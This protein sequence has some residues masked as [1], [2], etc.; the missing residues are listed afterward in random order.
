MLQPTNASNVAEN[1]DDDVQFDL[2]GKY[3]IQLTDCVT[4][5]AIRGEDIYPQWKTH[6]NGVKNN[7]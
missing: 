3:S 4:K 2:S 5:K 1:Y 6:L 7:N